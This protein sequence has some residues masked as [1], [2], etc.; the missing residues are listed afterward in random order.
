MSASSRWASAASCRY[1]ALQLSHF[2]PG[3]FLDRDRRLERLPSY[4]Y[5]SVLAFY[6]AWVDKSP[7][8]VP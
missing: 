4:S 5:D 7:E 3:V 6:Q 8:D 2:F 1:L